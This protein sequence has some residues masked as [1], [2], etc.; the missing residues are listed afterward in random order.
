MIAKLNVRWL[1]WSSITAVTGASIL[2]LAGTKIQPL[3]VHEA[4]SEATILLPV[5][6]DAALPA[7]QFL[8]AERIVLTSQQLVTTTSAETLQTLSHI[9]IDRSH[10]SVA[11]AISRETS[12]SP[13]AHQITATTILGIVGRRSFTTIGVSI[14]AVV[15]P[16]GTLT[17]LAITTRTTGIRVVSRTLGDTIATVLRIQGGMDLTPIARTAVAI[18]IPEGTTLDCALTVDA[19]RQGIVQLTIAAV[20]AGPGGRT[21][22]RRIPS[23]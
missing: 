8:I 21:S 13:A 11:N 19:N 1:M 16:G 12:R 17:D 4:T 2:L 9:W 10:G 6:L 20:S 23:G 5:V 15:E 18:I 3:L 22:G 14:V 7:L